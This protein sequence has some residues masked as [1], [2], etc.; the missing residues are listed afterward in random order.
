MVVT[1][2]CLWIKLQML[3]V[4]LV[5]LWIKLHFLGVLL[6]YLIELRCLCINNDL[7]WPIWPFIILII[8]T[9]YSLHWSLPCASLMM[10][11]DPLSCWCRLDLAIKAVIMPSKVPLTIWLELR[12]GHDLALDGP[13]IDDDVTDRP[14]PWG[15]MVIIGAGW[16]HGHA[17]IN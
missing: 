14:W 4:P 9:I 1:I 16:C 7:W 15:L 13:K 17:G 10:V 8:G 6:V 5:Y 3:G 11:K 2:F 12:V